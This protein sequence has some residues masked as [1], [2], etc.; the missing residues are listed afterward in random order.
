VI[1]ARPGERLYIHVRN[2]DR[3]NCHSLYVY[4]LHYGYGGRVHASDPGILPPCSRIR[5]D[6]FPFWM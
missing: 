6:R 5:R 2:P 1:W 3:H 4:G